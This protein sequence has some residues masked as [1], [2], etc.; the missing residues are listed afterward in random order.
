MSNL[1]ILITTPRFQFFIHTSFFLGCAT[2]GGAA[3]INPPFFHIVNIGSHLFK[4][5]I[6]SKL[7]AQQTSAILN[8]EALLTEKLFSLVLFAS[9]DFVMIFSLQFCINYSQFWLRGDYIDMIRFLQ[10]SFSEEFS[11][12]VIK[13]S[14]KIVVFVLHQTHTLNTQSETN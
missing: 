9:Y 10:G 5:K 8:C 3:T 1:R 14:V 13:W 12:A 2:H 11:S 7:V 6:C 4:T